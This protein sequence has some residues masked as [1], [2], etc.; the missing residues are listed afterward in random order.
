MTVII[1]LGDRKVIGW[2]L[3]C[4]MHAI[5]TAVAAWKIELT[6]RGFC[7]GLTFHSDCGVQYAC[8]KFRDLIGKGNQVVHRISHKDNCFDNSVAEGFF[9]SLKT[10]WLFGKNFK[11]RDKA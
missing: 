5:V 9:Q 2:S 6:N 1:D 4:L 11:T 7:E 8:K 3:S 10:E